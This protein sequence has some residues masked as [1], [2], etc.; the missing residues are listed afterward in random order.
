[1]GMEQG[2]KF[3]HFQGGDIVINGSAQFW[4]INSELN[5]FLLICMQFGGDF[6]YYRW[7]ATNLR[8]LRGIPT[9]PRWVGSVRFNLFEL[10]GWRPDHSLIPPHG[11]HTQWLQDWGHLRLQVLRLINVRSI[12]INKGTSFITNY[13]YLCSFWCSCFQD[14]D[15]DQSQFSTFKCV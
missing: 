6:F 15:S 13:T 2:I 9:G 4:R 11:V 7:S 5:W 14:Q 3:W 12:N 10:K 1:M 8:G